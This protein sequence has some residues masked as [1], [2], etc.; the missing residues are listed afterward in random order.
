MDWIEEILT[1]LL[2]AEFP[3]HLGEVYFNS[4]KT[5]QFQIDTWRLYIA[6][7]DP[8]FIGNLLEI[9]TKAARKRVDK[10]RDYIC[11]AIVGNT[12]RRKFRMKTI[13]ALR[14]TGMTKVQALRVM[15]MG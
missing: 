4:Q 2:A 5:A 6:G 15:G 10:I 9:T 3:C 1:N 12:G 14:E 13:E 8:A 11:Q 7:N